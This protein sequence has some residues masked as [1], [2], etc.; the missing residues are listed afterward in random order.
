MKKIITSLMML[1]MLLPAYA[2]D[3]QKSLDKAL[4]KAQKKEMKQKMKDYKKDGYEVMGSRTMEVALLK[5]YSKLNELGDD[6]AV[7]EGY[8]SGTKSKNSAEQMAI[9]NATI[10]YAQK[11]GSTVKGRVVTD[12]FAD[13]TGDDSEFEKFYA[14]YERLVEQKVKNVLVPS[15]SVIRKNADG[16]YE[17]QAFFIVDENK[18]RAAR[19]AALE[20][21]LTESQ[22]AQKYADSV[23]D[24]INDRVE[25]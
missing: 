21:A 5:H 24:F 15:Y 11:A 6:G 3:V 18:A 13:G 20:N 19:K 2:D 14:A 10:K 22:L 16:T 17:L 4:Q 12:I 9:N 8:S 25:D 1:M 23:R 7:F